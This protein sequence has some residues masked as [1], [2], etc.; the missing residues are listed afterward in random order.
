MPIEDAK[1]RY[2]KGTDVRLAFKDDKVVEAKNTKT[3][4]IHTPA[5]FAADRK[6]KEKKTEP[7]KSFMTRRNKKEGKG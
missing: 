5:E 2:K 6:K 3:G 1:Y 7:I 4:A